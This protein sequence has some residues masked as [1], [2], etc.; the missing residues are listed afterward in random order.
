MTWIALADHSERR[1][2]LHGIGT[3]RRDTPICDD[4]PDHVLP[5]G[6]LLFETRLSPDGRPQLLF[7]Y[8]NDFPW[9]RSLKFQAIPGGGIAMVQAVA[10]NITHATVPHKNASRTD[11]LRVTF[12]WDAPNEWGRL[13]V[14]CPEDGTSVAVA[15][16]NPKP[17]SISDLRDLMLG[18]GSQSFAA[19]MVFAA[20]SDQIEPVGPMPTLAPSTPIATPDGYVAAKDLRRGDLVMTDRGETVPVLHCVQRCVPARGSFAP[21]WLRAPYFGLLQDIVV[22]PEQ[23]IVIT[24]SDVEYLFNQEAVLVPARH[25]TNGFSARSVRPGTLAS[26]TQLVLPG[27]NS[28]TA[29]GAQLESL[30]IGRIRRKPDQL[31]ASLLAGI[32]RK[33]LPEHGGSVFPVLRW[34][35][36]VTLTTQRVA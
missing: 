11:V 14:E 19:D 12:S 5:R 18:H 34:Y 1:F 17:V 32:D 15:V 27:H 23:R 33:T 20:L 21:V 6:S 13:T 26:Y 29:A 25:L 22:S 4:G 28:L 31:A 36:A 16:K 9:P 7:G 30:Y 24:G 35:E 10:K 8:N 3:D 2:S